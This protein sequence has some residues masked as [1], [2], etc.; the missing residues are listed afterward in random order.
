MFLRILSSQSKYE[1]ISLMPHDFQ[2][3]NELLFIKPDRVVRNK[4]GKGMLF[5][6]NRKYVL[7][8][9][10]DASGLMTKD[11]ATNTLQEITDGSSS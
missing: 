7:Q 10:K 2:F 6:V 1:T 4:A 9:L 3:L 8:R 5:I 11:E